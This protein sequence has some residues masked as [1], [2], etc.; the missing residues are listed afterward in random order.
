MYSGMK[1]R[2]WNPKLKTVFQHVPQGIYE[3]V[4]LDSSV[5]TIGVM[6]FK[7]LAGILS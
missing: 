4:G 3:G 1:P 5:T 7:K 2:V 6:D